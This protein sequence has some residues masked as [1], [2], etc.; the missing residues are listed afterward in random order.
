MLRQQIDQPR[1]EGGTKQDFA[2]DVGRRQRHAPDR[3]R[4]KIEPGRQRLFAFG[5]FFWIGHRAHARS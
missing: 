2:H 4:F 3:P 5:V 1:I